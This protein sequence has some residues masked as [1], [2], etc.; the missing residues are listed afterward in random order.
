MNS[1]P[2][3]VLSIAATLFFD[4]EGPLSRAKH[5]MDFFDRRVCVITAILHKPLYVD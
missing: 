4:F 1:R 2:H 3:H 5:V